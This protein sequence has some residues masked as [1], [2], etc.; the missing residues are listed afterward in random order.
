MHLINIGKMNFDRKVLSNE[1]QPLDGRQ[2][3]QLTP[4]EVSRLFHYVDDYVM[5]RYA[6][7]MDLP[8]V[9]KIYSGLDAQVNAYRE[10]GG[11]TDFGEIVAP[12][13]QSS[14][15]RLNAEEKQTKERKEAVGMSQSATALFS[16]ETGQV[17]NLQEVLSSPPP[18]AHDQ[19]AN[20]TLP[21]TIM[22]TE[23][24]AA[25]ISR[26]HPEDIDNAV[27]DFPKD[28]RAAVNSIIRNEAAVQGVL[29]GQP[30]TSKEADLKAAVE[31]V[32]LA[33]PSVIQR[34]APIVLPDGVEKPAGTPPVASVVSEN[35]AIA[36]PGAAVVPK[37]LAAKLNAS[38]KPQPVEEVLRLSAGNRSMESPQ[39]QMQY[40][41]QE[42]TRGSV[43]RQVSKRRSKSRSKR[44]S[45]RRSKSRSRSRAR[46]QNSTY[47]RRASSR[48][49]SRK[50]SRR[51]K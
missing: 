11:C 43:R 13:L 7:D 5:S 20:A 40:P 32:L 3:D 48:R 16:V 23:A 44:R 8:D 17:N 47:H 27:A 31:T 51:G 15:L 35:S 22:T 4:E 26:A 36:P 19:S 6:D 28:T 45:K 2:E 30:R 14:L 33:T 46:K 9:S 39:Q 38:N 10:H 18:K 29:E 25:E 34:S 12:G 42:S 24:A 1:R 21:P 37:A 49:S 50:Q 41:S